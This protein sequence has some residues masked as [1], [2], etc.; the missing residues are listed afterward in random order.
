M[1]SVEERHE[2]KHERVGQQRDIQRRNS[3]STFEAERK[4]VLHSYLPV[5]LC[6]TILV[7]KHAK[8]QRC[9][10]VGLCRIV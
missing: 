8:H 9:Y 10:A 5:V 3:K 4:K 2:A 6:I 7:C 1:R